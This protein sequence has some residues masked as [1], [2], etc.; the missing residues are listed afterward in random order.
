MV[1]NIENNSDNNILKKI[2][3]Y[4]IEFNDLSHIKNLSEDC[5]GV[6]KKFCGRSCHGNL[7]NADVYE[8]FWFACEY[9]IYDI[10]EQIF[11]RP[12]KKIIFMKKIYGYCYYGFRLACL[13]GH[14]EV[15][16]WMKTEFPNLINEAFKKYGCDGF[17]LASAHGHL[18]V[19]VWMKTEFSDLINNAFKDCGY[20]GFQLACLNG[21]SK[22]IDWMKT[23]FP[24]LINQAF[25]SN[26]YVR[27]HWASVHG[28]SHVVN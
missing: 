16:V 21:R 10:I 12:D 19:L 6:I 20:Y 25:K 15:L 7:L 4:E 11:E 23:E 13:N 3:L 18:K 28:Q 2:K 8:L 17:Q 27:F 24:D 26:H 9:G 22:V 1:I 14:L 5:F